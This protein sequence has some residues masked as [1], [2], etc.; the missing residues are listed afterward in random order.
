MGANSIAVSNNVRSR[1]VAR[2]FLFALFFV[3]CFVLAKKTRV[4]KRKLH[5]LAGKR[6]KV[7]DVWTDHRIIGSTK[8]GGG[9]CGGGSFFSCRERARA[10]KHGRL[11]P[12]AKEE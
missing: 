4:L 11:K 5:K 12:R 7:D 2:F 10:Q 6:I 8:N 9:G 3:P 1:R